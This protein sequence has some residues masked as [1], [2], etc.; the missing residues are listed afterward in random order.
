[1]N[2]SAAGWQL[3]DS[4]LHGISYAYLEPKHLLSHFKLQNLIKIAKLSPSAGTLA[5]RPGY[6]GVYSE[7]DVKPSSVNGVLMFL[8]LPP[9]FKQRS[10]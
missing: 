9:S 5:P 6:T 3:I 2:R 4:V 7:T 10:K 8:P 1:M